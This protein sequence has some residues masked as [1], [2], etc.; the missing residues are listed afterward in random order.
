MSAME[1]QDLRAQLDYLASRMTS[2]AGVKAIEGIRA[3]FDSCDRIEKR[4]DEEAQEIKKRL[5]EEG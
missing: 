5:I 1:K 3:F 4:F 2:A